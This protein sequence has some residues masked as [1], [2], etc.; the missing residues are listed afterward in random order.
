MK[1]RLFAD[2]DLLLLLHGVVV[3]KPLDV[4]SLIH[5]FDLFWYVYIKNAS[6]KERGECRE[7]NMSH[8]LANLQNCCCNELNFEYNSHDYKFGHR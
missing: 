3:Y 7:S 8:K 4:L 5:T 2:Q 1:C 6:W